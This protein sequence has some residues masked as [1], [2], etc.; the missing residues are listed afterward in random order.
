MALCLPVGLASGEH[1]QIRGKKEYQFCLQ[2]YYM[3]FPGGFNSTSKV[4]SSF[5]LLFQAEGDNGNHTFLFIFPRLPISLKITPY[6]KL[7]WNAPIW[8]SQLVP[9]Q[10]AFYAAWGPRTLFIIWTYSKFTAYMNVLVF[11]MS[12]NARHIGEGRDVCGESAS[13]ESTSCP[14]TLVAVVTRPHGLGS[15]VKETDMFPRL[16]QVQSLLRLV[17]HSPSHL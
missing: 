3:T 12:I 11:I 16:W 8:R 5:L 14:Q 4:P 15:P 10:L 1:A 13:T 17:G 6:I 9:I 2:D 7:C